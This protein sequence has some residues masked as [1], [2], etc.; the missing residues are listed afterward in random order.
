[1]GVTKAPMIRRSY[2]CKQRRRYEATA[3]IIFT[4][5]TAAHD[6][7]QRE[8][9]QR[10]CEGHRRCIS[11]AWRASVSELKFADH[12]PADVVGNET[13]ALQFDTPND[14]AVA[15]HRRPATGTR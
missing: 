8:Y 10:S 9:H 7:K 5:T 11:R 1:M 15:R 3:E 13:V 6:N 12:S 2:L 4:P 14:N